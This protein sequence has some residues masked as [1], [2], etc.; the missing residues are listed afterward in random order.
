MHVCTAVPK[1]ELARARLLADSLAHHQP[2][3]RFIALVVDDVASATGDEPY[4]TLR[5]ELLG[6]E[7]LEP[8]Y[9]VCGPKTLGLALRPWL[10]SYLRERAGDSPV[11]WV[12]PDACAFAS[13][14]E[15]A[16][17]CEAHGVVA[18]PGAERLIAIGDAP[19]VHGKLRDWTRRV[20]EGLARLDGELDSLVLARE[21]ARLRDAFPANGDVGPALRR[22]PDALLD[23]AE[24]LTGPGWSADAGVLAQLPLEINGDG[25][26]RVGG[27]TL[28]LI[29]AAALSSNDGETVAELAARYGVELER[30]GHSKLHQTPYAH[31]VLAR[32]DQ[33]GQRLRRDV[34]EATRE[35][36]LRSPLLSESGAHEFLA[37]LREPAPE[38]GNE[39]VS[40]FHFGLYRDHVWMRQHYPQL[41]AGDAPRFL[42]WLRGNGR[43]EIPIPEDLLPDPIPEERLRSERSV[44]ANQ[45]LIRGVNLAGFLHAEFGLGEAARLLVKGLDARRIP[46]IPLEAT[47][48]QLT[49]QQTEFASLPTWGDGF[50]VNILCVNGNLIPGLVE[51]A[52]WLFR[53]RHTI[54]VWFWETNLLPEEWSAAFEHLDEI[55]VASSF[56]A[57]MIG[58]ASPVPVRAVPL[59]V[60]LPPTVA[61]DRSELRDRRGRLPVH[62]H[63]RLALERR[64]Q[65]PAGRDRRLHRPPS[66][67]ARA[68]RCCSRASRG[69]TSRPSSSRSRC[70]PAATPTS[71]SSTATCRGARRTRSWPGPTATCRCTAPRASG[72]RS[73][74]R[75][76]SESRVI[77][78]AYGGNLEFMTPDNSRLVNYS[79]VPVGEEAAVRTSA[80]ARYPAGAMWADPDTHDGRGGDALGVREPRGGGGDGAAR[81]ARHSPRT[82][83]RGR[84]RGDRARPASRLDRGRRAPLGARRPR[85]LGLGRD[86]GGAFGDRRPGSRPAGA[87][88]RAGPPRHPRPAQGRPFP[89]LARPAGAHLLSAPGRRRPAGL[90]RRAVAARRRPRGRA[91]RDQGRP[92]GRA[93]GAL[94]RDAAHRRQGRGRVGQAAPRARGSRR[95]TQGVTA[96]S[97]DG[98]A[99]AR[100]AA[101]VRELAASYEPPRFEEVPNPDAALFLS[102]DRSSQWLSRRLPGRAARG[103]SSGSALLW[104]HRAA[105]RDAPPRAAERGSARRRRRGARR[106]DLQ[107]RR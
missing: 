86:R 80:T 10:L 24:L 64:A 51:D 11:V 97:A 45:E 44:R 49:R 40:R 30:H 77:A 57:E 98:V 37:W 107:R 22:P 18:T 103:R 29:D 82:R 69:S 1:G 9:R 101:R 72:S 15:L 39:G 81:R 36:A 75:C 106:R 67:P 99:A 62:V 28:R 78:T 74:R 95:R 4:E 60:S 93:R 55:W 73:P 58:A 48:S 14:D 26:A 104:R 2:D 84:R 34:A 46:V 3:A 35:G 23:D 6:V 88:V 47:L 94:R 70:P 16:V 31:G 5:P 38:G 96:A 12:R 66:S 7:G 59:P 20:I 92:G 33:L 25:S 13:L 100:V 42:E 54:A 105:R 89:A 53:D 68:P 102:G 63:V 19:P 56:M 52:P 43:T 87:R 85:S 76:G 65:E 50:P 32:D 8:L 91:V 41:D 71:T 83:S 90:D 17:L 27:E 79:M 21:L 61:F